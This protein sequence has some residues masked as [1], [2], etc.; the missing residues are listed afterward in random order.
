MI[1]EKIL[2]Q[3]PASLKEVDDLLVERKKEK[4]LTYEQDL[5]L[6]YAKKF[7]KL[8]DAKYKK[9]VKDL[10]SVEGLTD[11]LIVKIIDI[12][13]ADKN[14]LDLLLEKHTISDEAKKQILEI[15]SNQ[16]PASK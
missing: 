12:V 6:K 2:E 11:D 1:G 9:I 14:I 15:T 16:K 10:S 7:S 8:T 3:R 5:T 4:E 13:P